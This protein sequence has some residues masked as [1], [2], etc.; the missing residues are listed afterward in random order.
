MKI[1]CLDDDPRLEVVLR[2]FLQRLGHPS[3]FFTRPIPFQAAMDRTAPDLVLLDLG[4]GKDNGIDVIRWLAKAHSR[5]PLILLSGHGSNLLDTARR[6]AL[7]CG[8]VVNGA[9]NKGQMVKELPPL[10]AMTTTGSN[11]PSPN[12][13]GSSQRSPS[14]SAA[15][16]PP[17]PA[18]TAPANSADAAATTALPPLAAGATDGPPLTAAL[19]ANFIAS[20]YLTPHYQPIVAPVDGGLRGAEVLARLS[21]PGKRLLGAGEFIP[22]AEATGL[23][24]PLTEALFARVGESADAIAALGLQFLSVNLSALALQEGRTLDLVRDLV[25]D[26]RGTCQVKIELTET[27]ASSD[28]QLVR[29]LAAQFHLLGTS[30]AI[31][32]FGMGYNSMRAL[33]ELPFDTL[34]I[35]L[36]F[37]AEMFDSPKALNLL[38]AIIGFGRQLGMTLVA[39]GV[40]TAAQRDVLIDCGIDLAQGYL[41]GAPMPLPDLQAAFA[42]S[43]PAWPDP[44]LARPGPTLMVIDDD[45]RMLHACARLA[46]AWGYQCQVYSDPRAALAAATE[47]PPQVV[48]VDVYMPGMDGFET[49][50]RLRRIARSSRIIAISGEMIRGEQVNVLEICR[51]LGADAILPKPIPPERLRLL[52]QAMTGATPAG[53]QDQ[54]AAPAD[55]VASSAGRAGT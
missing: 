35:D 49:I 38:R 47:A 54:R 43:P 7:D 29:A 11:L 25:H 10:L 14:A 6:V 40:E 16:R 41:F 34:K 4:L 51:Q 9:V 30:L 2:R 24:Y 12:V 55:G 3:R 31:D 26:L 37:V 8:L 23:L 5:V 33:A 20:G 45:Q 53:L 27:A 1:Y 18:P 13:P 21:P 39:E 15:P 22:L 32:D 17:T 46:R 28:P 52:L 42:A 48:M 44:P 50:M 19:L 36:S